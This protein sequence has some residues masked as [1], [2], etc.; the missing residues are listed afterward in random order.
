MPGK[1]FNKDGAL[2][3]DILSKLQT[4]AGETKVAIVC[5]LHTRKA[6]FGFDPDPVDD[7]L[8]STGLTASADVVYA[9]YTEQGKKGATLKGRGRDM[10]DVDL[11]LIFDPV[12]CCWQSQGDASEAKVKETEMEVINVLTDL[13]KAQAHTVARTLSKDYSN[14]YKILAS[15]WTNRKIGKDLIE[16]KT[17][18]FL[19]PDKET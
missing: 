7:V 17:Y 8:G 13:G 18:Y 5:S 9:L 2:F 6:S 14:T 11:A 19:L 12:T 1:D 4:L 16:G 3:D 10:D 15:L